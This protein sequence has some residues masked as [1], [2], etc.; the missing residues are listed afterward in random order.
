MYIIFGVKVV[1]NVLLIVSVNIE[2]AFTF[3]VSLMSR[4]IF[5][6]KM[7]QRYPLTYTNNKLFPYT[8]T[9]TDVFQER[10]R[11]ATKDRGVVL[12]PNVGSMV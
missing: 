5:V 3:V 7:P 4:D 2:Y 9:R 1:S 12:G 8:D 10:V 11:N 6:C